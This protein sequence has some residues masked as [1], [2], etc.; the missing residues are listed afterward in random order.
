LQERAGSRPG[1]E[2][3]VILG[4]ALYVWI[5]TE[6]RGFPSAFLGPGLH[7][8]TNPNQKKLHSRRRTSPTQL[9]NDSP[10]GG[11]VSAANQ[12]VITISRTLPGDMAIIVF[13]DRA[14]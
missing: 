9:G 14:S 5:R 1:E 3:A 7:H 4:P 10:R 2:E 11:Q 13:I 8:P 6:L 12:V